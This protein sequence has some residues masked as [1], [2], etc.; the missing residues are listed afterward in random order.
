MRLGI[1]S[2][3]QHSSAEEW[4]RK[5]TE[6]GCTSVVFPVQSGSD[7]KLIYEYKDAAE[8]YGLMI[9]EVGIWRNALAADP[10]ERRRNTDYCVEQLRLA[11]FLGARCAV[12]VAGSFGPRWDGHYR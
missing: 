4:A 1:S 10:D 3:L 5:Q 8:K 12:N 7:E 9:A 6:L 2:P 11:D